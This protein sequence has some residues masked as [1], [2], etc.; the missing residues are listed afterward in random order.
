MLQVD[1]LSKDFLHLYLAAS[2]GDPEVVL[3]PG[4]IHDHVS[5]QQEQEQEQEQEQDEQEWQEVLYP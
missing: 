2:E 4:L 1:Y 3:H 5:Q